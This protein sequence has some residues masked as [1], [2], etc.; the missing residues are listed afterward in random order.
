VVIP[1]LN[2]ANNLPH[3]LPRIPHWVDEVILVDGHSSD[4]TDQVA[5]QLRPDIRIIHEPEPG[6]GAALRA[7]FAEAS[8]DM[9]IML[10]ADG[11]TDPLEIPLFVATL[12]AGA[13]FAKGSRF[14]QGGG[15]ADMP[16]H[17]K[18]GNLA[19]V[20]LVRMLFG[21]SY[22]DLCY[23]YN[24]FWS[25]ILPQLELDGKGFEIETLMNVR[26]LKAG[27]RVAE[28]PSFE[29]K[30]VYGEGRLRTIPDGWRVLTTI[31]K[32][33]LNV[34]AQRLMHKRGHQP[35][36]Q[37]NRADHI[38]QPETLIGQP[39]TLFESNSREDR[40]DLEAS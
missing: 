21:G 11:S 15:T 26:A 38:G 10:D 28:V 33:R 5:R 18:L 1:T 31:L 35:S 4:G 7:G 12:R 27:L 17:R 34:R 22:S 37:G 36:T 23:G 20:M 14:V 9:I 39:E 25:R 8:G 19:F 3:V 16:L 24:A 40:H 30:R 29:A 6:K 32:E 2:E 13:D